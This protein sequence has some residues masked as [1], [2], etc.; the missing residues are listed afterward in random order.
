M[1]NNQSDEDI[2]VPSFGPITDLKPKSLRLT[3][4][5]VLAG[6]LLGVF[7]LTVLPPIFAGLCYKLDPAYVDFV[8]W[9][10][11]VEIAALGSALGFFFSEERN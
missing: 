6:G 7:A 3:T 4:A 11:A 9:L 10:V 8:K 2:E 1:S 5:A